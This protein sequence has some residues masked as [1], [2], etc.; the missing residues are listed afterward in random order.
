MALLV[1]KDLE[2]SRLPTVGVISVITVLNCVILEQRVRAASELS[3]VVD[4]VVGDDSGAGTT[5]MR[6][7]DFAVVDDIRTL[8]CIRLCVVGNLLDHQP[9]YSNLETFANREEG[10][11]VR[12][13]ELPRGRSIARIKVHHRL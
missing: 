8:A 13:L 12:Q 6:P 4:V 5:T 1:G 9:T 10:V 7:S 11:L 2:A 3:D